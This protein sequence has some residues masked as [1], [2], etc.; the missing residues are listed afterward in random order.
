MIDSYV[1]KYGNVHFPLHL[2]QNHHL[3]C[4]LA[5][6]LSLNFNVHN[7]SQTVLPR[8]A[9][10]HIFYKMQPTVLCI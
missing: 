6:A 10:S 5:R 8:G 2:I 9:P 1:S 7:S 3:R 4:S